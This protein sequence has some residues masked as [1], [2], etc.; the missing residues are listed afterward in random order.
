MVVLNYINVNIK[1]SEKNMSYKI[2]EDRI[3]D[4]TWDIIWVSDKSIHRIILIKHRRT[5]WI[6]IVHD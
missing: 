3:E 1:W 4:N 5:N 2:E 6:K